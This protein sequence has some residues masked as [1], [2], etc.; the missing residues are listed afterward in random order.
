MGLSGSIPI[1]L[2]NKVS[3][4]QQ[5]LFSL[6]SLPF[7][8]KLLWAPFVDSIYISSFG[9]RKSW[10]VP[11]QMLSGILMLYGAT[12]I[13][14]WMGEDNSPNLTPNVPALTTYFL[15]LYLLMATQDIA[16]DGWALTMLSK[17]NIGY[18][19]TCNTLGQTLGFFMAHIGLLALNDPLLCNKYLRNENFPSDRGIISLSTFLVFWAIVFLVLTMYIWFFRIEEHDESETEIH[20][21]F[22]TYRHL[23][24]CMRL[25]NVQ[26]LCGL[27]LT[28]RIAFSVTD[29][30][31]SLKLI[32]F[33]MP[34]EELALLSPIL[35]GLGLLIPILVGRLTSGPKPLRMFII[36]Y[37]IRIVVILV[38]ACLLP[39]AQKR[40]SNSEKDDSNRFYTA[41][42]GGVILHEIASN[43]MYVS[44][45]SFFA[46]ISDPAI[47]GTYMTLLNTVSNLGIKWPNS[48]SL[49]FIE[50]LTITNCISLKGENIS[51]KISNNF[52]CREDNFLEECISLGGH[53]EIIRDGYYVL[54]K[55][56]IV[57]GIVWLALFWRKMLNLQDKKIHEW[58]ISYFTESGKKI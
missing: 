23:G 53:C 10:L 34:K 55:F 39:L 7:S 22:Q 46:R 6:V 18:A 20:G 19:S 30:A 21:I 56:C 43:F 29:S 16:V 48:M 3:Y 11:V 51:D 47:G 54:V 9:R 12:K 14:K 17:E 25:T 52:N 24:H 33:G 27:L 40:Y 4:S 42:I 2:H 5:A 15:T 37:P 44:S 57:I 26:K 41:L 50:R 13:E 31:T 28:C 58:H 1:L 49:Y 38:Y 45:M 36:G 35:V 32:E 8:L